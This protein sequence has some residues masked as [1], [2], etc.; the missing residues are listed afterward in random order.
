MNTNQSFQAPRPP[1]GMTDPTP[2]PPWGMPQQSPYAGPPPAPPKPW[3]ERDGI[4]AKLLAVAGVGITLIGVVM[5]LVMAVTAGLLGPQLRVGGGAL[6]SVGLVGAAAWINQ[7]DGGRIGAIALSATGFAGL[8]LCVL[9]ATSFYGWIPPVAGLVAAA[10]VAAAGV[11]L[12]MAWRSQ[13]LACLLTLGAGLLA[14]ALTETQLSL[15]AF[16]LLLQAAGCVPEFGRNWAW[17]SL[18]RSAPIAIA[19]AVIVVDGPTPLLWFEALAV[20]AG[21]V[22]LLSGMATARRPLEALTGASY[23]LVSLPVAFSFGILDRPAAPIVAT[24]FVVV[25]VVAML[26]QR[27]IGSGTGVFATVVASVAVFGAGHQAVTEG[28]YGVLFASLGLGVIVGGRQ[29]R[30]LHAIFAG[31]ASAFVGLVW[32][33]VRSG[34]LMTS[35]V[36]AWQ[37]AIGAAVTAVTCVVLVEIAH[38]RMSPDNAVIGAVAGTIGAVVSVSLAEF[39]VGAA[40]AGRPG[41]AAAHPAVTVTWALAGAAALALSLRSSQRAAWLACGLTGVGLALVKLFVHDLS[42]LSG[43]T[44]AIAFLLVGLLLLASG[45]GY[46]RALAKIGRQQQPLSPQPFGPAPMGR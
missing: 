6:L 42:G 14:P 34:E 27:P 21:L 15:L 25:T 45:A 11:G 9:A 23:F 26:T 36:A 41:F 37:T 24:A 28:W 3:W 32:T 22:A 39:A 20:T 43:F 16:L 44:R 18:A 1:V 31:C 5:L 10:V 8:Y 17:L 46:A 35:P 13:P 38:R 12:A 7:R 4:V 40:I 29:V 19:L 30:C 2:T 33:V